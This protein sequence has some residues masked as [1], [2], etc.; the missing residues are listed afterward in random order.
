[1]GFAPINASLSPWEPG[2]FSLA[3]YTALVLGLLGLILFLTVWLGQKKDT[4]EKLGAFY[5]R[6]L[7]QTIF[8]LFVPRATSVELY[9]Y[10]VRL[11]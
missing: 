6:D 3:V 2:V 7:Q 8:R 9:L 4:P 10:K 1:M 11:C 5:D